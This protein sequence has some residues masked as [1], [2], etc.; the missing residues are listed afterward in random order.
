[1]RLAWSGHKPCAGREPRVTEAAG[2][3]QTT[4][5]PRSP[6]GTSP[7]RPASDAVSNRTA[8]PARSMS[9]SCSADSPR[10]LRKAGRNGAATPKAAYLAAY[11]INR[12]SASDRRWSPASPRRKTTGA[13]LDGHRGKNAEIRGL[14]HMD[15]ICGSAV[16][17][18]V[19][20]FATSLTGR[21]ASAP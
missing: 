2:A 8:V 12:G 3:V 13:R 14:I 21:W 5:T 11:G 6:W 1:V 4:S 18:M 19:G 16:A 9:P 17:G 20:H 15:F 10:G 7:V